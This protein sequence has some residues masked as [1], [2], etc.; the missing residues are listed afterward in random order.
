MD[1]LITEI[2]GKKLYDTWHISVIHYF[3]YV[4]HVYVHATYYAIW[5]NDII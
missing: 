4:R 5:N 2:M 1:T 3:F